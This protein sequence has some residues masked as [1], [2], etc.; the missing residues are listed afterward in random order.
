[1]HRQSYT[2]E[3]AVAGEYCVN[4]SRGKSYKPAARFEEER[5]TLASTPSPPRATKPAWEDSRNVDD[6]RRLPWREASQPTQALAPPPS[7]RENCDVPGK[8]PS[9]NIDRVSCKERRT[10]NRD[11]LRRRN[12]VQANFRIAEPVRTERQKGFLPPPA[13]FP[14]S[15]IYNTVNLH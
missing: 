2:E 4:R 3:G 14:V 12:Q 8:N 15:R 5:T 9:P 10:K 7:S 1:M 13:P 11:N 6:G